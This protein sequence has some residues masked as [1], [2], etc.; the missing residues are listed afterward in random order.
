[1]FGRGLGKTTCGIVVFRVSFS[2]FDFLL[3]FPHSLSFSSAV[4]YILRLILQFTSVQILM[5]ALTSCI[6]SATVP[7]YR[8]PQKPSPLYPR[9]VQPSLKHT[10]H[11][12]Q[13][14]HKPSP[15]TSQEQETTAAGKSKY[16]D[17]YLRTATYIRSTCIHTHPSTP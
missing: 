4:Q 2:D 16:I 8:P 9:P 13:S 1:M 12:T 17:I 15:D 5:H 14:K 6:Q 7:P 10:I 3:S 11:T